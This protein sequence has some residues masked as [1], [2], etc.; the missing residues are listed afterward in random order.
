M[1]GAAQ[2]RDYL[3]PRG[4]DQLRS[5]LS[6]RDLAI[7]A[8]VAEL[9]LMSAR[10]IEAIHFPLSEHDNQL[11]AT[12]AAQRV[13][14]RLVRD[15]LLVRLERR[16]GG[17]R[18]GSASYIYG[19]GRVGQRVLAMD[20]PRRRYHEPTSR[21][22]DHTLSIAQLVV[23]VTAAS[24][25]GTLD[26]IAL[27]AEPRCYRD[28]SGV[29]GRTILRPDLFL[30]IGVGDWEQ[31]WFIE[32][33]RGQESL[34]VVIRK[35]RLYQSYYQSGKEQAAHGV[36]PRVCWIVPDERRA[37]QMHGAIQRDSRLVDRLFIVTTDSQALPDMTGGTS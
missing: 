26:V 21:F 14:A 12:R 5:E 24:R 28:F 33:D 31:R 6:G 15:R 29:A 9:R 37:E 8:Q 17:V 32:V 10:Q 23:D 3:G 1:K 13:L 22:L 35:C 36:F 2:P 27:Q 25:N 18:A 20:G 11:A 4:L 7:V 34:P 30:A 19:L 16:L